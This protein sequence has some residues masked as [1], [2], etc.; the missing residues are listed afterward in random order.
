MSEKISKAEVLHVAD[1]ARLELTE[2]EI[3]LMTEQ[4]N[5]ILSYMETLGRADTADIEPTTHAIRLSNVFRP[6]TVKESMDRELGLSNAPRTDG[7]SFVVP[8]VI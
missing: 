2:S 3:A 8:K 7:I 6:D 5:S 1:L 4:M